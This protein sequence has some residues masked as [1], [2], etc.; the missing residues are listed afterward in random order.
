MDGHQSERSVH[1][2]GLETERLESKD[3]FQHLLTDATLENVATALPTDTRSLV[4]V[5]GIGA[6]MMPRSVARLQEPP[7]ALEIGR[8]HV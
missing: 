1:L 2:E 6:R 8:A 7:L 4:A 3:A 5:P